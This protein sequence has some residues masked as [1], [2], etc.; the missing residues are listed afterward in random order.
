STSW[1]TVSTGSTLARRRRT[2]RAASIPRPRH[3]P[4]TEQ[5][6]IERPRPGS[7]PASRADRAAATGPAVREQQP[8]ARSD[9]AARPAQ[10]KP[11]AVPPTRR[12]VPLG[13]V[14]ERFLDEIGIAGRRSASGRV[15]ADRSAVIRLA[16]RRLAEHLSVD[17]VVDVIRE[18]TTRTG[19]AG[20]P[21][22]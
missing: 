18:G 9:P 17:E 22:F 15:D 2:A 16:L 4:R 14:E 6:S 20:R 1:L 21:R 8:P 3:K 11:A 10:E 12:T 5:V 13:P 7:E 19:G